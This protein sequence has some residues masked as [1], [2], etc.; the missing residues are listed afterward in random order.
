[1]RMTKIKYSRLVKTGKYENERLEAEAEVMEGEDLSHAYTRLREWVHDKLGLL[2]EDKTIWLIIDLTDGKIAAKFTDED[3]ARS[4][5][6]LYEEREHL[7]SDQK[8]T[9]FSLVRGVAE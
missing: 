4:T 6:E 7:V 9:Y 8:R 2:P 5:L 1:M 3:R